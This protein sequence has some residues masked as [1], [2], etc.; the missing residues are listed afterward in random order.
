LFKNKSILIAKHC[1]YHRHSVH[2]KRTP[3]SVCL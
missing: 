2:Y 1:N 3:K